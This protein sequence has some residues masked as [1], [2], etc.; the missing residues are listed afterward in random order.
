MALGHEA[1]FA[2]KFL[3]GLTPADYDGGYINKHPMQ[4]AK[5]AWSVFKEHLRDADLAMGPAATHLQ[6]RPQQVLQATAPTAVTVAAQPAVPQPQPTT[7]QPLVPYQVPAA[8]GQSTAS[9]PTAPG[10]S[11]VPM[12]VDMLGEGGGVFRVRDSRCTTCLDSVPAGT[13]H[14]DP[15]PKPVICRGCL[16]PGH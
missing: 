6:Q 13:H 7:L 5:M 1:D 8:W 9:M 15:C 10:H 4:V 2:N 16:Q 3:A 12:T 11:V 14:P